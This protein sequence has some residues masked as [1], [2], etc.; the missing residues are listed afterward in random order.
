[1]E[2][3]KISANHPFDELISKM[4]KQ[5]IQLNSKKPTIQLLKRTEELKTHFSKE[6]MQMDNKYKK[7]CSVSLTSKEMQIQTTMQ[8]HLTPVK[9][10]TTKKKGEDKY[11]RC[12]GKGTRVHCWQKCKR[13]QPLYK[14]VWGCGF[15][16]K[17][18]IKLHMVSKHPSGCILEG[19]HINISVR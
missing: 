14:T 6:N 8:C 3:E 4:Y 7:R 13:G 18:Q 19:N 2:W 17:L 5:L 15:L 1:M 10:A 9:V 16:E 12:G 11:R